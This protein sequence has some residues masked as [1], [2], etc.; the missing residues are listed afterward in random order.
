[1]LARF[2]RPRSR[3]NSGERGSSLFELMGT[4][5]IMTIVMT[6]LYDGIGSLSA[7]V[8]GTD[9]RLQNLGE[10]RHLMATSSKDLR[11]AARLQAGTSPF[12]LANKRQVTFY[13]NL[14]SNLAPI[15]ARK[16]DISVD[17]SSRLIEKLTTPDVNSCTTLCTYTTAQPISRFVGR[18]VANAASVPLFRYFDANGAELTN[19]PL[20]ATDLLAVYSVRITLSIKKTTSYP[21]AFTTLI[22]QVRLPNVDYQAV[23]G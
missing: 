7:A 10:A 6:V 5:A 4:I 13:A 22:N 8:E 9:R 2:L 14:D 23:S 16:I 17:A 15:G 21:V 3:R 12:S 18:F 1:M 19:V 11:T 20:N